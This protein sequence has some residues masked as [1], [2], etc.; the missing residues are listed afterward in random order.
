MKKSEKNSEEK[1][2][3]MR[4]LLRDVY[5]ENKLKENRNSPKEDRLTDDQIRVIAKDQFTDSGIYR[6]HYNKL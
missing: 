6:N 5:I 2:L 4:S 1:T 3:S